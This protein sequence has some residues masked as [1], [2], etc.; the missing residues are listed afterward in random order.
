M[1]QFG[2]I[3]Y[4]LSH[5][6]SEGYFA[7][8][9]LEE[10]IVDHHYSSFP[11]RE[12]SDL[13]ELLKS[14]PNL[15]GLNVTIPY[16]QQIIPFLS[17]IS[18]EAAQIGAVNT[19]Q[20]KDGKLIGHNTDVYGFEQSF[21]NF[22]R[23][24]AFDESQLRVLILGSGGASKAIQYVLRKYGLHYKVISR[25]REKGD[26]TYENL[27][28]SIIESHYIVINC[29]PLGT[30]PNSEE[31]PPIPYEFLTERHYLY[32]LIYNP[33]ETEFLKRGKERGAKI[34]NGLE[35]LH[36]Q[37]EKSWQIWKS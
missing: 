5:S 12:I 27:T 18:A 13:M 21:V 10:N 24:R 26:L 34:Q 35:M 2:L 9:F 4:P 31:F 23:G 37:A 19:I 17:E 33:A 16:K 30:F 8:K 32:D 36:L 29:T 11:L 28:K 20:I 14:Q 7:K 6:F 25:K 1:T 15:S 3:G 22:V